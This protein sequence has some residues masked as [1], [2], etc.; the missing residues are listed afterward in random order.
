MHGGMRRSTAAVP[1]SAIGIDR[2]NLRYIPLYVPPAAAGLFSFVYE[3]MT[4]PGNT[5]FFI[6]TG[7]V[8]LVRL[9]AAYDSIGSDQQFVELVPG[10][11]TTFGRTQFQKVLLRIT[12]SFGPNTLSAGRFLGMLVIATDYEQYA[13][14]ASTSMPVWTREAPSLT[15]Y[16]RVLL[17]TS[18]ILT[19]STGIFTYVSVLPQYV[20]SNVYQIEYT[21]TNTGPDVIYLGNTLTLTDTVGGRANVVE[22]AVGDSVTF[23]QSGVPPSGQT[24]NVAPSTDQAAIYSDSNTATWQVT[25]R[26]FQV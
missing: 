11:P 4:P 16:F 19:G 24:Q 25:Y 13:V 14:G 1:V 3:Q 23:V 7:A 10:A 20:E 15:R 18:W 8:Q 5:L 22:I 21:L 9:E 26:A 12:K 6:P 2:Q 17:P